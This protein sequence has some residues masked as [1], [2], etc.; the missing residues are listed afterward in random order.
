MHEIHFMNIFYTHSF[1]PLKYKIH[2]HSAH[3]IHIINHTHQLYLSFNF[4]TTPSSLYHLET[5]RSVFIEL[6]LPARTMRVALLS[7]RGCP[8]LLWPANILAATTI[9]A[10]LLSAVTA[11]QCM[12]NKG[13][14]NIDIYFHIDD[15]S[16][17]KIAAVIK[18]TLE[19]NH[20]QL[21]HG[22]RSEKAFVQEYFYEI[23]DAVNE[24]LDGTNIQVRPNLASLMSAES[25]SHEALCKPGYSI[26]NSTE[27]FLRTQKDYHTSGKS[28]ILI[29]SCSGNDPYLPG[30]IHEARPS[31]CGGVTGI[32]MHSPVD[33]QTIVYESILSMLAPQRSTENV[34]TRAISW[35]ESCRTVNRCNQQAP[36][37]GQYTPG[38]LARKKLAVFP[39][40]M[41]ARNRLWTGESVATVDKAREDGLL[42]S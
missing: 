10:C 15:V 1:N 7:G 31:T 17:A 36:D 5:P 28:H 14:Y 21:P 34:S 4:H 2:A 39:M 41:Q 12:A 3:S 9:L 32:A 13:T 26:M 20:R 8:S 11:L 23:I 40:R 18:K 6:P 33:V 22:L 29:L 16:S 30:G 24:S 42:K 35:A 37:F 27:A 19:D 38:R 25:L